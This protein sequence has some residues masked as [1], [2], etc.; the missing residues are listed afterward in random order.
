MHQY[1]LNIHAVDTVMLYQYQCSLEAAGVLDF[2]FSVPATKKTVCI[3]KATGALSGLLSPRL[4]GLSRFE[5][6]VAK[7]GGRLQKVLASVVSWNL[8]MSTNKPASCDTSPFM[9]CIE[10]K[11]QL[12]CYSTAETP[13]CVILKLRHQLKT[14]HNKIDQEARTQGGSFDT[15]IALPVLKRNMS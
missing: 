13:I 10:R 11:Y 8:V 6:P 9:A 2:D 14:E 12:Q 5:Y 3:I 1:W 4:K 7:I 15:Q